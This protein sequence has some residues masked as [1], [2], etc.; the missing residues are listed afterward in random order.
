MYPSL[1][2]I[3]QYLTR[4]VMKKYK[5]YQGHKRRARKWLGGVRKREPKLFVH[6]R[7][8]LGSPIG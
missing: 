7:L 8:G 1:R 4:W 3:E 5:R 6:W 2:N